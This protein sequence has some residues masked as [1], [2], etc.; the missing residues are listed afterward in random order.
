MKRS[1][2]VLL[3]AVADRIIGRHLALSGATGVLVADSEFDPLRLAGVDVVC[4]RAGRS[5]RVKVQPDPYFGTDP[6][7]CSDQTLTYYRASAGSYALETIAHHITREPGWVV[8]STA[9]TVFYYFLA[10][11]QPQDEVAALMDEAD[12]VFFS[13]LAVDRDELH[14]L[15]MSALREWFTPNSERYVSRPVGHGDHSG[16]CRIVPVADVAAA[17]PGITVVPQVF[18]RLSSAG[19]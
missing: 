9:D 1:G 16:W 11:S 15:P 4:T 7:K 19:A 17:V 10:I 3:Q 2:G 14:V 8:G 6:A 12:G 13:E 18:A 5:L